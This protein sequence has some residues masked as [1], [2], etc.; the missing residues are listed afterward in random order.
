MKPERFT[1][2]ALMIAGR[3]DGAARPEAPRAL[4]D[5]LPGRETLVES[6]SRAGTSFRVVEPERFAA[7]VVA[8]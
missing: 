8:F 1:M 4:A 2:P 3:H 5:R 7:D 6:V